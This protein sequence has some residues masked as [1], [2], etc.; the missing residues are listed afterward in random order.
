[1]LLA[2]ATPLEPAWD[3]MFLMSAPKADL[4]MRDD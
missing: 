3:S 4:V 2:A 1:V